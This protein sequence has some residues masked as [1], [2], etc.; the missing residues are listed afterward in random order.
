MIFKFSVA[1]I[2][3]NEEKNIER[4]IKSVIDLSDD[5]VVVDSGST[6]KTKEICE[7]YKI[8]FY[9]NEF[10]DYGTQKSYASNLTKYN[11]VL[12]ID[13]DEVL[14]DDMRKSIISLKDFENHNI[15]FSF[16]RLNFF[17]G[18]P[19]RYCGWYPDRKIRLWNK[20]FGNWEGTVHEKL[21]FKT[22]P[23]ILHLKGDLLHYTYNSYMEYFQRSIKY[24]YESAEKEFKT[25]KRAGL[26][27]VYTS[28]CTKFFIIYIFKLGFLD[29]LTGF[30]ISITTAYATFFKNLQLYTKQK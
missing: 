24:A 28:F 11:F 22:K 16:N 6:D 9:Y 1:I 26:L 29:G 17:C 19:V 27:K 4:C 18:K 10:K 13:A 30:I 20:N 15:A 5:I 8:R 7:R 14:S 25:G 23:E 2:T 21:V 3:F 12:N